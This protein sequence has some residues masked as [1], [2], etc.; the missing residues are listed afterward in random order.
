M[1]DSVLA[2]ILLVGTLKALAHP[3]IGILMWTWV[4][5]MNPHRES[6]NLSTFPVA[7][8]VGGATLIGMFLTRDKRHFF[9]TVPSFILLLFTL[10]MC[11]THLFALYPDESVNMLERVL[12]INFMI[13]V[14]MMLLYTRK[15]IIAL[16]WVLVGSLGYYGVKGGA[17]TIATGGSYRVW[18]PSDS[19]IEGNNEV[20]LALIMAIPLMYFLRSLSHRRWVRMAFLLAML[21]TAAAAIGSQS[22]GALLAIAAMVGLFWTR[23]DSTGPHGSHIW[24]I[25]HCRR[26]RAGRLHAGILAQPH[27]FD[28]GL[29]G[30]CLRT[31]AAE[32]LA[33]GVESGVRPVFW[34]RLRD[35]Q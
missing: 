6:W 17:F 18:G 31:G 11:I 12:K 14:L 28:L 19:F 1:R 20:A 7:A 21:L 34:R 29:Q 5:I 10:W 27:G 3:Y 24:R 33:D 25:D 26:P 15:H 4:S 16:V 30:G 32:C 13:F 35:I 8:M 2:L 9:I 22:R 23:L